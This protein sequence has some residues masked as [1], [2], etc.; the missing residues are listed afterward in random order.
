MVFRFAMAVACASPNRVMSTGCGWATNS[1]ARTC[2][3]VSASLK[4]R[5][6]SARREDCCTLAKAA[7]TVCSLDT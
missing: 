5:L 1:L 6:A 4:A 3:V 7:S 2:M